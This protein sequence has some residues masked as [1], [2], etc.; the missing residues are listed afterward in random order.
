MQTSA[1]DLNPWASN[2]EGATVF[3]LMQAIFCVSAASAIITFAGTP[4]PALSRAH[5]V[6]L[7]LPITASAA[8]AGPALRMLHVPDD[9]VDLLV[10]SVGLRAVLAALS[11]LA[12]YT[13]GV[14]F[15]IERWHCLVMSSLLLLATG[16][17]IGSV[18]L[19]V[20]P[21]MCMWH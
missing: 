12:M 5:W 3:G 15:S 6:R 20:I 2:Y 4:Q 18:P 11:P 21:W 1:M 10:D 16:Q 9:D 19:G 7:L 13:C 17:F 8:A 14:L